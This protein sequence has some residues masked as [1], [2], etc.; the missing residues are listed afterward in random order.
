MSNLTKSKLYGLSE[1][2]LNL[3]TKTIS[4]NRKV[5]KIV[6]FGSRAKGEFKTGSDIDLAIFAEDLSF[7][8]F[9]KIKV[10]A[11]QILIQ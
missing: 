11:M 2:V 6:L 10:I 9:M 7:D 1:K 8:E 3:I 4:V 5:K